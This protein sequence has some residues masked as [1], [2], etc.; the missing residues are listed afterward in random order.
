MRAEGCREVFVYIFAPKLFCQGQTRFKKTRS[1]PTR[2][3]SPHGRGLQKLPPGGGGVIILFT[4]LTRHC[5]FPG[6]IFLIISVP[7]DIYT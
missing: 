7:I 4:I 3:R 1:D 5:G 2:E 6:D